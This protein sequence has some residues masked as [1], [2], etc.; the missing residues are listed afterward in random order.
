MP[1]CSHFTSG[2]ALSCKCARIRTQRTPELP[3]QRHCLLMLRW[4][5]VWLCL[6]PCHDSRMLP[7]FS[8][9]PTQ[10]VVGS[11]RCGVTGPASFPTPAWCP[12]RGVNTMLMMLGAA[13]PVFRLP[14]TFV[15]RPES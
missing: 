1:S 7:G 13:K 3:K 6:Q 4:W 15:P 14:Y 11:A 8:Q 12:S 9:I 5:L 2:A 10:L